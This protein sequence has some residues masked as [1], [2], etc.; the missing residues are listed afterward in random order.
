MWKT[1]SLRSGS[2]R[3]A[4][5]W[6]RWGYSA[7]Q[8]ARV[9]CRP[10]S[11]RRGR[12]Q[13]PRVAASLVR[14]RG[15]RGGDDEGDDGDHHGDRAEPAG[16]PRHACG[17]GG[18]SGCGPAPGAGPRPRG[19]ECARSGRLGGLRVGWVGAHMGSRRCPRGGR[20]GR[21][22]HPRS[23]GAV[24][25]RL[26]RVSWV[27]DDR[28][29]WAHRVAAG[30]AALGLVSGAGAAITE[31]G[32]TTDATPP[33]CPGTPCLAVSQTTGYQA[34]IGAQ[35]A[36]V[37]VTKAG[38]IVAWSITQ[39]SPT[40]GPDQVLRRDG[41]WPGRGRPSPFCARDRS[42]TSRSSP[43]PGDAPTAL[44]RHDRPVPPRD[45]ARRQSG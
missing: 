10:G 30:A 27:P 35:K 23:A 42:S 29:A 24:R 5:R 40:P 41:G 9:D 25:P 15:R 21:A 1:V 6:A 45:D 13:R 12:G 22:D 31:I 38:R 32:M 11:V 19:G 37:S 14:D 8:G 36:P 33:S 18:G 17:R 4:I 43:E 39:G 7:G 28:E 44:L 34:K 20:D 16:H 3:A 2:P 26:S